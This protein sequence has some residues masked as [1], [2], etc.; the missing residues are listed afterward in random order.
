MVK[1]KEKGESWTKGVFVGKDFVS[2]LNLISTKKGI[3]KARTIK[4]CTPSIDIEALVEA[5]GTPWN[6]R[7]QHL[8][9]PKPTKRIPP[10]RGIEVIG[11]GPLSLP[12]P[13]QRRPS[14]VLG[15]DR[16]TEEETPTQIEGGMDE[17]GGDDDGEDPGERKRPRST[18]NSLSYE[19]SSDEGESPRL[20]RDV[21]EA[22]LQEPE[23]ESN[24][25]RID[26][27]DGEVEEN[28]HK[29]PATAVRWA[30]EQ[31]SFGT[32]R[33]LAEGEKSEEY[34]EYVRRIMMIRSVEEMN[35]YLKSEV[36]EYHDDEE[37]EME[38]L[39]E[40]EANVY[41][42]E[43]GIPEWEDDEELNEKLPTWSN[44]FEDGPPKL[45]DE[46]LENVDNESRAFEIERLEEM[47]VLIRLHPDADKSKYKFLSTKVVYDWRHREGEWQR[48]GRLVAREYKW[49]TSY[50]LASLFSPTRVSSTIKMLVRIDR[51][52]QSWKS[53]RWNWQE[54]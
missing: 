33:S 3:V 13:E 41:E 15:S 8:V 38:E 37:V 22:E 44:D 35:P 9:S 11:N 50:D 40:V 36:P 54:C 29:Y 27:G 46:E 12:V 39:E 23:Q 2:N 48:R 53:L 52:I 31:Q 34:K 47:G 42:E 4:R 16:P 49:L 6:G 43:E 51:R 30:D 45:T 19:P 10:T 17:D 7:Q 20:K 1:D 18:Q 5:T 28:P 25:P 14:Q 21:T 24:R 26:E 32:T